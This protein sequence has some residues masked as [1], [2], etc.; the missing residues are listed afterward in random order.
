[1]AAQ[2]ARRAHTELERAVRLSAALEERERLSRQVHDGVVQVLALVAKRGRE[3]GG[4][5]AQSGEP[6]RRA[7]TRV[8]PVDL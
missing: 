5:A 8:A 6:G 4:E 1:M 2:T 3:L 7:G